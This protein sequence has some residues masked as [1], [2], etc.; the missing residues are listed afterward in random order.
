MPA[1]F[2]FPIIGIGASAGGV[3]ALKALF[4]ALP[5]D[6]DAAL[7]VVTH[8]GPNHTSVLPAILQ[9]CCHLP[10]LAI[11]DGQ[12]PE[13]GRAYVLTTNGSLTIAAGRLRV[14]PHAGQAPRELRP[15][16]VFL[17]SL[18]EDQ[19]DRAAGILLS[20]SGSDGTLGLKAIQQHGGLTLA[21]GGG[22]DGS[23]GSGAPAYPEMPQ[24]AIGGGFVDLVLP[25]GEM[26][27]RLGELVRAIGARGRSPARAGRDRTGPV[28]DLRGP[29]HPARLRFRR[30]QG[31]DLL[32]AGP[33]ADGPAADRRARRLSS[34]ISG[35]RPTRPPCCSATC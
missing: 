31:Q 28:G 23:G 6:L 5:A 3:E 24:S 15:I 9:D 19:G 25:V 4:Q 11:R 7:V 21:Q 32:P 8:I 30:L 1:R 34:P 27:A 16:D 17:A 26:P 2:G 10:V 22:G 20:G 12:A 18:A 29:A 35:S 13:P 14:R 33:A